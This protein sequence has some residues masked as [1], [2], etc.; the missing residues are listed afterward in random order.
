MSH[1]FTNRADDGFEAYFY[2]KLRSWI[3]THFWNN[4]LGDESLHNLIETLA[5]RA[6]QMRR[7]IDRVWTASSIEL[8]DDW[9][10]PFIGDLV[11]AEPLS[12]Q[13]ARANRVT[14]ANMTSYHAR[15]TTRYLL[16]QFIT[17]IVDTEGYVREIERWLAR[18]PHELDMA[19]SRTAPLSRGPVGGFPFFGSPRADD[20]ALPAFD[21]FARLPDFGPRRGRAASF[22]YATIHFNLVPYET[23]PVEMATPFWL[24]STRLTLDPS[25]RTIPLFHS[26]S[27]DHRNGQWPIG[28]EEFPLQMR[29]ARFN[30]ARFKVTDEALAAIGSVNVTNAL[31]LWVGTSFATEPGFLR[32][33]DDTLTPADF[34]LFVDELLDGC[35]DLASAK[36]R[37]LGEDVLLDVGPFHD[38]RALQDHQ[39]TAANLETW[40]QPASI[41][42]RAALLFDPDLGTVQ[43]P[44]AL[45]PIADPVEI[46][47]PRLH[48]IG[49][50]HRIGAG[51]FARQSPIPQGPDV[52]N[53]NTEVPVTLP[54]NGD[55]P[56][57]DNRTHVIQ[58]NGTRTHTVIG[59]LWLGAADQTRPYLLSRADAGSL[60]FTLNGN[61]ATDADGN[62]IHENHLVID[63]L[64]LGVLANTPLETAVA[65]AD[66][67]VPV[68]PARLILDGIWESVTLRHV[69]LDPGGEQARLDPALG[70]A[71]PAI[72]LELEGTIKTLTIENCITG[73]IIET[74]LNPLLINAGQIRIKD[75]VLLSIDAD[76]PALSAKLGRLYLENCTV[77]GT[78]HANLIFATNTVFD[79][80]LYVT[81]TQAS[82]LR[83]SAFGRYA[84][85]PAPSVLPRQFECSPFEEAIAPETFLSK[86]FGDP[87]F[88]TLA[89]LADARLFEGGEYRTEIGVGNKR[90]WNR[91]LDDLARFVTKFM[92]V[93]QN[94]QIYE[95]VGADS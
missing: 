76:Q 82:C 7:D 42:P 34:N 20:A 49:L 61:D 51:T 16:D 10:V 17:D 62:F 81:N 58:W 19:F 94:A 67:P 89:P 59:E 13:N 18:P 38:I 69:S 92:P 44:A 8:A 48:H 23:Y 78:T 14:A 40:L 26:A 3:P 79:G 75:S 22:D 55:V 32:I 87:S 90:F 39:I 52:T 83:F 50:M 66:T 27:F 88:A 24:D 29:C 74:Q 4:D 37:Q 33:L 63:G 57:V 11:G 60:D 1:T 9:A 21:E 65:G 56:I 5:E 47:H 84:S 80:P 43:F 28:P 53:A 12:A 45:D 64:W 68:T 71:I 93:G 85:D 86:R 35:R 30:D 31:S 70:R 54:A 6:A 91:R 73:P 25:G 46:F 72:T 2:R 77:L 36:Q 41:P 95:D 15:K